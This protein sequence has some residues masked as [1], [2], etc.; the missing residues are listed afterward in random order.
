[1]GVSKATLLVSIDKMKLI[2]L[3]E[4][5]TVLAFNEEAFQQ[6]CTIKHNEIVLRNDLSEVGKDAALQNLDKVCSKL[7]GF[8]SIYNLATVT[9]PELESC[10]CWCRFNR[11]TV[12]KAAGQ[13]VDAYDSHCK[14][15]ND[16]VTC[17][18]M[19][20]GS[21]CNPW[22]ATYSTSMQRAQTGSFL[23]CESN[24]TPCSYNLCKIEIALYAN[25]VTEYV[26][27]Y[28]PNHATFNKQDPG[29]N[30]TVWNYECSNNHGGE[31]NGDFQC[32]GEYHLRHP[33]K[34]EINGV[35]KQCCDKDNGDFGVETYNTVTQQCCDGTVASLGSC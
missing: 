19:D 1:M 12:P 28:D 23:S 20:Y 7:Q 2:F 9:P 14:N 16:A 13:P 6:I 26:N 5:L 35:I 22:D 21:E 33:F 8:K 11:N 34:T 32:C 25:L 15:Y 17:L 31:Y 29:F 18:S 24:T 27:G 30:E 10:G 3:T 4:I